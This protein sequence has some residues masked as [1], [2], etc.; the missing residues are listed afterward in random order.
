MTS[1]DERDD[2]DV[3]VDELPDGFD[4]VECVDCGRGVVTNKPDDVDRCGDCRGT[5]FVA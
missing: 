4:R 5:S 2:E 3:D 1:F